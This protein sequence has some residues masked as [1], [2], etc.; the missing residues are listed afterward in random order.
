MEEISPDPTSEASQPPTPSPPIPFWSYSDLLLLI[1][2]SI[3]SMILG[4]GIVRAFFAVFHIH[5]TLRVLELL[6][7][8]FV[9]YLI[10]FAVLA[11]ML[12]ME[13]NRPFWR[14][15]GWA[16]MRM[17]F[18]WIV[19]CGLATFF[20][21]NLLGLLI[22]TPTTSNP[23]T[24][25]L[26]DRQSIILMGVFG[27]TIA[28]L[29]E[30]LL[31]RGFLQPLLVRSLGAA[32]GIVLAAVPFGLLHYHEYG[33]SWRHAVLISVAGVCFGIMRHVTGS[34]K[35]STIMHAA[36][37]GYIFAIVLFQ[38]KAAH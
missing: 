20:G 37:N 28:P 22:R 21:V 33:N 13:Y 27:V 9:G 12:R 36:Y 7:Q 10:L 6:P 26:M 32:G 5:S 15:L 29:S 8:Q 18:L 25:L 24:D 38:G 16:S 1:G 17:P 30:E 34:T 23:L 2:L 19:I 14:S 11:L 31:F 35:A 4:W 3:P